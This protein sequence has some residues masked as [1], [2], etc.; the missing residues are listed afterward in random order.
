[1]FITLMYRYQYGLNKLS[2][3]SI[4]YQNN[5][6]YTTPQNAT[7]YLNGTEQT[8]QLGLKFNLGGKQL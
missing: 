2:E 3:R 6:Q 7:T 1:M 4:T 5:E 8:F